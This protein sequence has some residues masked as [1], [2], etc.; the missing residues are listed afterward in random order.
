MSTSYKRGILLFVVPALALGTILFVYL[1]GGRY[2]ETENAYVK[3]KLVAI[4]SNIDGRVIEVPAKN[5]LSVESGDLLFR[6]DPKPAQ[7][8]L[9]GAEAELLNVGQRIQSLK[10]RYQQAQLEIAAARD[11]IQFLSKQHQRQVSLEKQGLGKDADLDQAQHDLEV[12]QRSLEIAHQ[13][14]AGILAELGGNP[15]LANEQHSLYIA[16][17]SKRDQAQRELDYTQVLAPSGGVLTNVSLEAGEYVEA[18]KAVFTLVERDALWVEANLKESQ[19]THVREQ[20]DATIIIDAYP[21]YVFHAKVHSL[22]PATGAEFAVLPPQ[23]ATG[24]WVK[25]VQRIPVRL[26][27]DQLDNEPPLRAGMTA[28]V[29]IDTQ[30]ERQLPSLIRS[31]LANVISD[32][33]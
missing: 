25:V 17:K 13:R 20:Q 1:M 14:S 19:L 23:N 16:A 6:I 28:T 11:R 27:F 7:T 8:R 22:S 33:Q 15:Q 24:N 5:N 9:D 31:V 26:E 29:R 18:G 21:D 3:A 2:V 10:A 32:N 4:S 12:G 30:H